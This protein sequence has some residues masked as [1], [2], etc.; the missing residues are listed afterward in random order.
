M[1]FTF[2]THPGAFGPWDEWVQQSAH[3]HP[4]QHSAWGEAQRTA[5][6]TPVLLLAYAGETLVGGA[7]ILERPVKRLGRV[8][9][10]NRGPLIGVDDP[11]LRSAMVRELVRMARDRRHLY[12]VF[13]LGYDGQGFA[14][15]MMRQGFMLRPQALPPVR[16]MRDTAVLDLRG[17][18]DDLLAAMRSSTRKH[19]RQGLKRGLRI[20]MGTEEDLPTFDVLLE[21]LC[22]RRG[23]RRNIPGGDFLKVLWRGF[24]KSESLHM[25]VACVGDTPIAALLVFSL[26]GWVREW[27]IGWNGENAEMLPNE[28]LRWEV[29]R[30]AKEREKV[31]YDF[32]GF[33][34]P[35]TEMILSG[36]ELPAEAMTG[37][38][39]FKLGF[40]GRPL[41]LCEDYCY[42]P[43]PV[44]RFVMRRFG[45]RLLKSRWVRTRL[46]RMSAQPGRPA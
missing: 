18:M 37:P 28:L 8:G 29:M 22:Q 14:D 6:W 13:A 43:N 39:W 15:E 27:R 32:S 10:V 42:F 34:G 23:A 25:F 20:R 1:T 4:E 7:Q 46:N 17:S 30:W 21:A 33:D 2:R 3:P 11:Q 36:Q 35:L 44:G 45:D 9:Y 31:F 5:G 41:R 16:V 19:I 26:G 24:Q 40:G 38:S 12:Q